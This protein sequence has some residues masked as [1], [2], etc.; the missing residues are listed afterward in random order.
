MQR[1]IEVL[2]HSFPSIGSQAGTK[3][4]TMQGIEQP[5]QSVCQRN[6][7]A[8]GHEQTATVMF[9]QFWDA[10]NVRGHH[11]QAN[12][13]RFHQH[14]WDTIAIAVRQYMR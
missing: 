14:I 3:D 4:T 1:S 2:N 10:R 8:G 5:L 13:H 12:G 11:G 9:D 7:I 6:L